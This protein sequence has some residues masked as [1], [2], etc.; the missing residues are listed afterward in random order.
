MLSA[1]GDPIRLGA[2]DLLQSEDLSPDA[3]GAA[4]GVPG[5]L[6]AHHLKVLQGAGIVTRA[7]SQSDRRRTYVRLVPDALAGLLPQPAPLSASRVVFVCTHNSARSVLAEALWRTAS[8]VPVAS[9]GTHPADRI[10]PR[11]RTAARRAGLRLVRPTPH[12]IEDVLLPDDVVVSV[13]DAVNEHLDH[14]ANPRMHWSVPDP[15]DVDT[16]AAFD[17]ALAQIGDRVTQLAARVQPASTVT[18][19]RL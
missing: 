2:V 7:H 3:L 8:A 5:N 19:R 12:A 1:L 14:V 17:L 6:L 15:A 16:D 9:A 4:L 10:N 18:R 11:T 13:C